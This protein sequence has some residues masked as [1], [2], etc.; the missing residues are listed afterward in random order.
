VIELQNRES[1]KAFRGDPPIFITEQLALRLPKKTDYLKEKLALQDLARRM[2]S[3]P[4]EFLPL[5][6][7]L[8]MEICGG[9]AAGLSLYEEHPE[10]GV[11]RW[12]Y[13]RGALS[14]FEGGTAPR[15]FSPCGVTLDRDGPVLVSHPERL[16]DWIADANIEVPEVL[17]IPLHLDDDKP[18][19]TLWIVSDEEGHFDSGHARIATEL[20]SFVDIALAMLRA[21]ERLQ[22][23]LEE[24]E[25]VA[26]E[27]HHRL[28]NVFAL[29]DGMIRITARTARTPGEMADILSGRL[30]ALARAHQLVQRRV[31][32]IE[33][34]APETFDFHSLI[35]VIVE[36]HEQAGAPSKFVL[37]GAPIRCCEQT[38]NSFALILHELATN[39]AKY[40]VLAAP[41]GTVEI[42]WR[43]EGDKLVVSWEESGG[44]EILAPPK[45]H[46]FGSVLVRKIVRQFGGALEYDWRRQGLKIIIICPLC[47]FAL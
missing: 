45:S 40:G 27:M 1:P 26:R 41:A 6:V 32:D 7:D 14:S 17:L 15:D 20:A 29:T 33:G 5:F 9:V 39:A 38:A 30:L 31:L 18:L 13:L 34:N 35:R 24:Q 21:E 25:T 36:P 2:R 19:G 4:A 23:A 22:H 12:R 44:P 47:R 10:P 8:A 11:F 42:A 37:E 16:Y 43:V 46:G 3:A 28:N